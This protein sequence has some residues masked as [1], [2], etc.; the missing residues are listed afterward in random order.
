M[1]FRMVA[2]LLVAV[3]VAG[4]L[5]WCSERL[6]LSTDEGV[7]Q[8]G[9]LIQT[10]T[11]EITHLVIDHGSNTVSLLQKSK[12]DWQISRPVETPADAGYVARLLGVLESLRREEVI[13]AEQRKSR[14]ISLQDFGLTQPRT[15]LTLG[16]RFTSRVLLVG[17]EAPLGEQIYV[18]FEGEDDVLATSLDL[19]RILPGDVNAIR[20]YT[21]IRG[22]AASTTRLE[23]QRPGSGFIQVVQ[24]AGKWTV[25][26]P[27]VCRADSARIAYMLE[28]LY[29]TAA[30]KFVWDPPI[31]GSEGTRGAA[32]LA[33][34]RPGPGEAE[35]YNLSPDTAQVR[36]TV[37]VG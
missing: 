29:H 7:K 21:I 27:I 16:D 6:W 8:A 3:L 30:V 13:T 10:L 34:E 15:R 33:A 25:Q 5:V 11:D 1:R 17:N 32:T 20:D 35:P 2:R 36:V 12:D 24:S 37:W 22:D 28:T 18:K 26:Q 4:T 19:V 9:L 14:D 31:A 23:I